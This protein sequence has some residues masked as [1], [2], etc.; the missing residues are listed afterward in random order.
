[1]ITKENGHPVS[2]GDISLLPNKTKSQEACDVQFEYSTLLPLLSNS[3]YRSIC[4]SKSSGILAQDS[5]RQTVSADLPPMWS[6]GYSYSQ[7]ESAQRSRSELGFDAGLSAMPFSK[8]ILSGLPTN[9]H[10]RSGVA[11]S[12]FPSHQ[13]VGFIYPLPVPSHDGQGGSR[14]SGLGLENRQKHR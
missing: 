10:R 2:H 13:T 7:P 4:L 8:D 14:A 1:M 9:S 12:L 3:N 5:S 6:P 11:P